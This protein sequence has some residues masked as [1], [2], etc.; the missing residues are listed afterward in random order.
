MCVVKP[1]LEYLVSSNLLQCQSGH[2]LVL[3][4]L[5]ILLQDRLQHEVK[6]KV[7][8]SVLTVNS[9]YTSTIGSI[10]YLCQSGYYSI[11]YQ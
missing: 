2:L 3:I 8:Y 10:M 5:S 9:P 1:Y 7:M 6:V 4:L 11:V